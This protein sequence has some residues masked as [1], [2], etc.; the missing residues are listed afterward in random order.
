MAV[1][2]YNDVEKMSEKETGE[3]LQEL[4]M[5]LIKKLLNLLK[6]RLMRS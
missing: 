6:L 3:K 2:K 5:E 4:K 1:L